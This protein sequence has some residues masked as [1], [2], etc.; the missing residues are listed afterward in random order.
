MDIVYEKHPVTAERKRELAE[1]GARIIDARFKPAE[2]GADEQKA[3]A[4]QAPRRGRKS[5]RQ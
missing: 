5:G 1:Q 3:E 2:E 4:E